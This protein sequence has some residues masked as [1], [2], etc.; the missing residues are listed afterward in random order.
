MLNYHRTQV[1]FRRIGL[2]VLSALVLAGVSLA[3]LVL[4][5]EAKRFKGGPGC[6][7]TLATLLASAE[8]GDTLE[9]L[10]GPG[11]WPSD[12]A[13]ITKNVII[14]GGWKLIS[15]T[16]ISSDTSSSTFIWPAERSIIGDASGSVVTIDP[17]VL[18][19][20]MRYLDI[21]NTGVS[22]TTG[23]GITGVISNGGRVLLENVVI[24]DSFVSDNGG[25]MYLEVRGGSQLIISNTQISTNT[26]NNQG[27]GFE[28]RVYDGSQVII[29]NSQVFGNRA[30][31][32]NG[33]GGRI[34][35]DRGTVTI[36]GSTFFDNLANQGNGGGLSVEA[37]GSGPAYLILQSSVI[38]G[39]DATLNDK[40]LHISGTITLLDKQIFLPILF[41]N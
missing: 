39:N 21:V 1:I 10:T 18:S 38:S 11:V 2:V 33:G 14:E 40:N 25:G 9:V 4:N 6:G 23:G 3:V 16:C 15:P 35:I 32:G 28:I 8:D 41:K 13:V 30:L 31:D 12:G 27:G 24:T 26:S 7:G 34:L 37:I 36:A 20:T 17:S 19:L 5:A 29:K 22:A